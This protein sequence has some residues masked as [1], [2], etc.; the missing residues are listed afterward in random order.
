MESGELKLY[1]ELKEQGT[2]IVTEIYPHHDK[3]FSCGLK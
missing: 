2:D 3:M 1:L